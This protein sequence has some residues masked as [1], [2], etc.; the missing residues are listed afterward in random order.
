MEAPDAIT[1]IIV[2]NELLTGKRQDRHLSHA[3]EILA[4]RCSD[5]AVAPIAGHGC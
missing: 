1:L 4:A 2:G 5:S 3:I